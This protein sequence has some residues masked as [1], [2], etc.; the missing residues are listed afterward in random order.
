MKFSKVHLFTVL[1][2]IFALNGCATTEET[3]QPTSEAP[4]TVAPTSPVVES[5]VVTPAVSAQEVK[6]EHCANHQAAVDA[7]KHDCEQH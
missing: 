6:P 3:I 5:P 4:A 1:P 2:L 7:I